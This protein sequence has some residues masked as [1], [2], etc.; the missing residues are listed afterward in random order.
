MK[1][2]PTHQACKLRARIFARLK[3]PEVTLQVALMLIVIV[4]TNNIRWSLSAHW[5]SCYG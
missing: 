4:N 1:I 5:K 2:F 3:D